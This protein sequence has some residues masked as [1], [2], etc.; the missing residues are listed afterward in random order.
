MQSNRPSSQFQTNNT[1][2]YNFHREIVPVQFKMHQFVQNSHQEVKRQ[3]SCPQNLNFTMKSKPF[4][5]I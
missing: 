2:V 4:K 5:Q 3:N 1:Q